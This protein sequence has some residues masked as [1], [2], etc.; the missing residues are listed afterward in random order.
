MEWP[1]S[2]FI[3]G[4]SWNAENLLKVPSWWMR[5]WDT[6]YPHRTQGQILKIGSLALLCLKVDRMEE[7]INITVPKDDIVK[8]IKLASGEVN[9]ALL[10]I[11]PP[12]NYERDM[13][14]LRRYVREPDRLK[15]IYEIS[16]GARPSKKDQ[17][18]S[19]Y[20]EIGLVMQVGMNS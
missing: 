13:L 12:L 19:P 3:D 14:R 5:D 7:M 8:M 11:I 20:R 2:L 17:N 18:R 10:T 4:L 9:K 6:D 1:S 16:R 15:L